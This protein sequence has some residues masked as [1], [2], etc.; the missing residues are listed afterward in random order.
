MTLWDELTSISGSTFY[1]C[2]SLASVELPAG[3]TSIGGCTF[4]RCPS[5]ASVELPAGLTSIGVGA[6][7]PNC[8]TSHAPAPAV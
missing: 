5:L 1:E 7:P 8:A 6:F 3:L 4:P 2:S